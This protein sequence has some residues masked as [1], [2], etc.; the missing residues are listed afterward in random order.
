MGKTVFA[1]NIANAAMATIAND[2]K[3]VLVFSLEMPSDRCH[4]NS[5]RLAVLISIAYV[6]V[7]CTTMIGAELR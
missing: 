5:R 1:V 6:L 7:S 4:A 3:P 2:T